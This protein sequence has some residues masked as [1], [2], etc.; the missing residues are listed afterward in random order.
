MADDKTPSPW[1]TAVPVIGNAINALSNIGVNRATRK[2]NEKQYAKQR[3]DALSD[4]NMQN[5][6][7]SPA[8]QMARLQN[9][10]L[11]PRLIYGSSSNMPASSSV[12][13]SD[14]GSYRP[15]P[16]N[17]D[18]GGLINGLMAIYDISKK[19]AETNNI[20]AQ[21]DVIVAEGL[22]K[23]T[24]NETGQFQLGKSEALLSTDISIAKAR[25]DKIYADT[26]YT[27]SQNERASAM[28]DANLAV[29]AQNILAS[30]ANVAKTADERREINARIANLQKEGALRELDINLR[31]IGVNP[32][33]PT[34]MRVLGQVVDD[35]SSAID[36][37]GGKV[38]EIML[39]IEKRLPP[40]LNFLKES[41]K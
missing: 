40:S 3:A 20:L 24:Q 9:A 33:D 14:T 25:L 36:R 10:K 13:S 32:S 26:E 34:W 38:R 8:S 12:R 16:V 28:Q 29:A 27:L 22:L 19:Q 21:K 5:E 31:K 30:R 4:W 39:G 18:S 11:N 37:I 2:W 35:P 15:N 17:V 23:K 1:I 6:Y 41:K 7:N